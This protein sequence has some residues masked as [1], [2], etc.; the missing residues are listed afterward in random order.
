MFVFR[1]IKFVYSNSNSKQQQKLKKLFNTIF[2]IFFFLYITISSM[3]FIQNYISCSQHSTKPSSAKSNL[4]NS[5]YAISDKENINFLNFSKIAINSTSKSQDKRCNTIDFLPNSFNISKF[6]TENV[7][8]YKFQTE[9]NTSNHIISSKNYT[10]ASH[11]RYKS[12]ANMP[13]KMPVH[14]PSFKRTSQKL[15]KGFGVED[16]QVIKPKNKILGDFQKS[17]QSQNFSISIQKKPGDLIEIPEISSPEKDE[18]IPDIDENYRVYSLMKSF[19]HIEIVSKQQLVKKE[20]FMSSFSNNENKSMISFPDEITNSAHKNLLF[21]KKMHST[22]K[23]LSNLIKKHNNIFN[24]NNNNTLFHNKISEIKADKILKCVE[25]LE[26]PEPFTNNFFSKE[27]N[28]ASTKPTQNAENNKEENETSNINSSIYKFLL[29]RETS[30]Q[31]NPHF[32]KFQEEI[33]GTMRAVLI[34]WMSEVSTEFCL[35]RHTLQQAIYYLDK[36][37][38]VNKSMKKQTL[39]LVGVSSLLISSKLEVIINFSFIYLISLIILRRYN[40]PLLCNIE[41]HVMMDIV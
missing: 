10:N 4:K 36:Y 26:E 7:G 11:F 23:L 38:E 25:K 40:H 13:Y 3:N 18:K 39:Q 32:L 19:K 5:K 37:L 31:L 12:I 9:A 30:Y 24:N 27:R 8:P 29:I 1:K 22:P 15:D 20:S 2:R 6:T 33:N 21:F 16:S 28:P 41:K 35:K 17:F 34:D 14:E